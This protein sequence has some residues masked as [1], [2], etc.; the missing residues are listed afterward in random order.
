MYI[1]WTGVA[2]AG[3]AEKGNDI[4]VLLS[5]TKAERVNGGYRFTGHKH[6]GSLTPVWTFLGIHC[7]DTSDP[8]APRVVHAF[9]PRTTEG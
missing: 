3:L 6:F 1:Y 8:A 2:P 9:M 5:T 4:P 7:L